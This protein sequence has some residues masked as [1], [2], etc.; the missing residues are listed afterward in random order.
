MSPD[1][2][3]TVLTLR[4]AVARYEEL[5]VRDLFDDVEEPL[6]RAEALELIAL[7][8]VI[9]RK[10]RYGRQLAVRT[11]REAGA[12]WSQIGRA[13]GTSK[14]TAWETHNRWIEQQRRREGDPGHLGMDED[15]IARERRLAGLGE[16][17]T[18]RR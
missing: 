8:E 18:R 14:Q 1:E 12:S 6:G 15:A 17:V 3:D 11:A 7:G 4:T 2:L 5:R 10:A 9:A 16:W 13:M